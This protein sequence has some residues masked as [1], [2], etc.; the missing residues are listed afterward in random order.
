[1]SEYIAQ[2]QQVTRPKVDT[3]RVIKHV[4]DTVPRD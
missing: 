2:V 1:M 4:S 3:M